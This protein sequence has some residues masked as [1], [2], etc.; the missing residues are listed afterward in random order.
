MGSFACAYASFSFHLQLCLQ[1]TQHWLLIAHW[2]Q[3]QQT[4]QK[5]WEK[6]RT[7][8]RSNALAATINQWPSWPVFVVVVKMCFYRVVCLLGVCVPLVATGGGFPISSSSFSA[9]WRSTSSN[10]TG[11]HKAHK[12]GHRHTR[13]SEKVLAAADCYQVW[14]VFWL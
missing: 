4:I 8:G 7:F 11:H 3:Q 14:G 2:Q 5:E 12:H 6:K 10:S 9:V 1:H 13:T